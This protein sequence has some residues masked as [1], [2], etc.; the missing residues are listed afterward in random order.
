MKRFFALSLLSSVLAVPMAANAALSEGG[1]GN[2]NFTGAIKQDS[3][4]VQGQGT[5]DINVPLGNVQASTL[6]TA[7][8]PGAISS[9]GQ[10]NISVKCDKAH[11][12][13]ALSF[14]PL[15][16]QLQGTNVLHID[17]ATGGAKGVGIV[18]VDAA[19]AAMDLKTDSY[20]GTSVNGTTNLQVRA[21]YVMTGDAAAVKPGTANASMPFVLK[22]E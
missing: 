15:P 20:T 2:I 11:T 9:T 22:Y 8:A 19:G 17:N 16:S 14:D 3:C 10:V 1:G 4:S 6:G 13:V 5:S 7:A 21:T 18:L 12:K